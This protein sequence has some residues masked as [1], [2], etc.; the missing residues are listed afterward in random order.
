MSAE[1]EQNVKAVKSLSDHLFQ[2]SPLLKR[3]IT[4]MPVFQGEHGLSLSLY[5]ILSLLNE[6]EYMSVSEISLYF[7]IAKPNITPLVD[8][9]ATEGLVERVRSTEDRR[10]VFVRILPAGRER[11]EQ[12]A[13]QLTY[14]I[15]Q[16]RERLGD[17]DFARFAACAAEMCDFLGKL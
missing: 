1:N 5:Q 8:H 4:R 16:W 10:V 15:D 6:R 17:E 9:L 14:H 3:H 12:I 2:L 11:L 13:S 7:G